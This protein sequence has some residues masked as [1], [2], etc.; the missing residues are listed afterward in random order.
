MPRVPRPRPLVALVGLAA[1][2]AGTPALAQTAAELEARGDRLMA[3]FS[4]PEAIEAYRR[5]LARDST[6][7]SLL[8]KA[9]RAISNL[10][11]ETPGEEGDESRL[12]EAVALARRAVAHG[13]R[14]SRAHTTLAA[15]LGKLALFRGGKRKVELAREVKAEADRAVAL[16]PGDFAPFAILG[17]WNREI[18]TLNVFLRTFADAF[19][20]GVPDASLERSRRLLERAVALA[21]ETIT[22]RLELARTLLEMDDEAGARRHLRTAVSLEPKETLDRVQKRH[23]RALLEE[24]GP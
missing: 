7:V 8:W 23:A 3:A 13:P 5:G 14:V 9:S 20:G 10:A 17:V 6:D 18:A 24:I 1:L 21:P 12:E 22:P 11:D 15:A 19:F 4:T 2:S 16:D